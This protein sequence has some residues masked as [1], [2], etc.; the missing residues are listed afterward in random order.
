M[1]S[2]GK[3]MG[4][5]NYRLCVLLQENISKDNDIPKNRIVVFKVP[6]LV[7]IKT[8]QKPIGS[9]TNSELVQIVSI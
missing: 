1:K 2:V 4:W 3:K 7:T 5:E 8:D 6:L 9:T